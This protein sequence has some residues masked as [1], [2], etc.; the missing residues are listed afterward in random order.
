MISELCVLLDVNEGDLA[1][2]V[3]YGSSLWTE[4]SCP[5]WVKNILTCPSLGEFIYLTYSRQ[6]TV[7]SIQEILIYTQHFF[8]GLVMMIFRHI[9]TE[10]WV[11]R[12]VLRSMVSDLSWNNLL[13]LPFHGAMTYFLSRVQFSGICFPLVQ[14]NSNLLPVMINIKK[15]HKH[16]FEPPTPLTVQAPHLRLADAFKFLPD[17]SPSSGEEQQ[18][19]KFIQALRGQADRVPCGNPFNSMI[20]ALTFE[21]LVSSKYVVL[22]DNVQL[23]DPMVYDLYTKLIGY[24][25]LSPLFSIPLFSATSRHCQNE[26]S[27]AVVCEECGYCLNFGKGKFKK[28][29]FKPTHVFYCR[30]QKEKCLTICASTGRIYCSFCGSPRIKSYPMKFQVGTQQYIRA[31]SASN[32]NIVASDSSVDIDVV[33]PCVNRNCANT[34]LKRL[35]VASLLYICYSDSNLFCA[36]CSKAL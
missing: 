34:L 23:K 14:C 31:V 30:D 13:A 7:L 19:S 17:R 8:L 24:N 4:D 32:C 26:T 22:P 36:S 1:L 15:R 3:L 9:S 33:L 5:S 18:M 28:L 12:A 35:S 16:V 27:S 25:I 6:G 21:S 2:F 10:R 11:T 20:K 29:S